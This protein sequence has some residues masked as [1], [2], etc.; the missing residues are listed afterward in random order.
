MTFAPFRLILRLEKT[1]SLCPGYL[2]AQFSKTVLGR[3]Q[4]PSRCRNAT[5]SEWRLLSCAGHWPPSL[6]VAGGFFHRACRRIPRPVVPFF[7]AASWRML[8]PGFCLFLGLAGN[9]S[10]SLII[11]GT[12]YIAI[13]MPLSKILTFNHLRRFHAP[14]FLDSSSYKVLFIPKTVEPSPQPWHF[15]Q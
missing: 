10:S 11:T 8:L 7:R 6:C 5:P 15:G 9:L 3:A 2:P 14:V 4:I 13:R 1:V 12:L